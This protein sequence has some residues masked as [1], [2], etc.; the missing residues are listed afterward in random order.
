[1]VSNPTSHSI[2]P[3]SGELTGATG[4]YSKKLIDMVGLYGDEVKFSQAVEQDGDSVIYMVSDFLPNAINVDL[5][6]GTA[7]NLVELGT[8]FYDPWPYPRTILKLLW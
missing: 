2:D 8:V 5:I 1:M 6:F 4:H 3:L 7:C